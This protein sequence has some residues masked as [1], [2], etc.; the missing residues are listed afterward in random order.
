MVGD[1][2]AWG[3]TVQELLSELTASGN[4]VPRDFDS[5]HS[6]RGPA[7]DTLPDGAR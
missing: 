3:T 5:Q 4:W 2:Q 1:S 6:T 7:Y